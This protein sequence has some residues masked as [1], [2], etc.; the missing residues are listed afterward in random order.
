MA[1]QD[2]RE[3]NHDKELL[4]RGAKLLNAEEKLKQFRAELNQTEIAFIRASAKAKKRTRL[5][6]L[7]LAI[8]VFLAISS[9]A[10]IALWQN[11]LAEQ[12]KYLALQVIE[13]FTYRIPEALEPVQNLRSNKAKKARLMNCR[14]VLRNRYF[15]HFGHQRC[16]SLF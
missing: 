12:Q 8:G 10:G 1:E 2:Y 15:S 4:L 3:N 16:K 6:Q 9:T 7:S 5:L 13:G 14:L 11:Y